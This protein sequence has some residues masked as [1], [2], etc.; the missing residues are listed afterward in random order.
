MKRRIIF[1][2]TLILL[3]VIPVFAQ[4]E[5]GESNAAQPWW[6]IATGILAVPAALL[7]LYYTYRL[8]EKTRLESKK[9]QRELEREARQIS[10][11]ETSEV[12]PSQSLAAPLRNRI[13]VTRTQDFIVRYIILELA[14]R[15]WGAVTA[16]V[17]PLINLCTNIYFT[18]SA[19]RNA[20]RGPGSEWFRY[21]V[22]TFESYFTS[23]GY[24]LLFLLI[25][26]PLLKDISTSLGITPKDIFSFRRIK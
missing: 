26:W 23:F 11:D 15:A 20:M 18:S 13:I 6:K 21:V 7:G 17:S 16:L 8:S 22:Y 5:S 24:V 2:A 14:A 10:E 3:T 4:V 12:L 25:G 19:Y 9:L 1:A